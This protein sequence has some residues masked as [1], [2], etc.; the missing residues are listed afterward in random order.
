MF[1]LYKR[2]PAVRQLRE[3]IHRQGPV[4]VLQGAARY[5]TGPGDQGRASYKPIAAI[6]CL[7]HPG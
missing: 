3:D 2:C 5:S 4:R 7:R 6:R 1:G